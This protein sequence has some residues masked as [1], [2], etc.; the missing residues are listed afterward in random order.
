MQRKSKVLS[1]STTYK[2]KWIE[3]Q[4]IYYKDQKGNKR[5]W[6][7]VKRT[8][9]RGAATIIAQLIP[10]D[11]IVLVKQ[12]RP[13]V[14]GY[15]L[16]F[17]AGLVD[18]KESLKNTAI[19]ELE[20]ETGFIGTYLNHTE[21]IYSTPGMTD[22]TVSIVFIKVDENNPKN[23]QPLSKTEATEDIEVTLVERKN[24]LHFTKKQEELGYRID[25]K[26][27]CFAL[28]LGDKL[29]G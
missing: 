13:P 29:S 21:P 24:L 23:K 14:E 27:K 28:G 22:E 18:E 20:E 6:E 25:A 8:P 7:N 17:P 3:F 9:D 11:R 5:V 19:R 1:R 16:E 4:N 10:S 2:G 15:I 26:L 12:F